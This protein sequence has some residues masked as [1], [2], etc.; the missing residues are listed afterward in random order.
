MSKKV[1]K[2][3]AKSED[4]IRTPKG[5][6]IYPWV[7]KKDEVQD[8]YSMIL[9]VDPENPELEDFKNEVK[10]FGRDAFSSRGGFPDDLVWC[11]RDG[12]SF[13]AAKKKP[14]T[15]KI[16]DL[17]ERSILIKAKSVFMPTVSLVKGGKLVEVEDDLDRRQI[18]TG[19]VGAMEGTLA[20]FDGQYP[21]VTFWFSQVAKLGKGEKIAGGSVDPNKSFGGMYD[22]DDDNVGAG[23][24]ANSGDLD[25]EI[26]F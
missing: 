9:A 13:V 1:N 24:S 26:P 21:A 2:P 22:P 10:K 19:M 16:L 15:G 12:A 18:Y 11:I 14:P 5:I 20:A 25:D 4:R 17:M 7:F 23:Q 6:A 8:A 3:I